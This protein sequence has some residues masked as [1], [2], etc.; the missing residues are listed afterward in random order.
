MYAVLEIALPAARPSVAMNFYKLLK[1]Q[2]IHNDCV[3][4]GFT[5]CGVLENPSWVQ[6]HPTPTRATMLVM[7]VAKPHTQSCRH[8]TSRK[9]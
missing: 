1:A 5:L 9:G 3:S 8:S 4:L 6:V 7:M 2:S